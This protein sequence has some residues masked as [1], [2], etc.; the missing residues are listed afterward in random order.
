M[1]VFEVA[2]GTSIMSFFLRAIGTTFGSLWGWAAYEARG[3]DPVVCTAMFFIGLI[4]AVY[5][6]LGSQHTKAGVVAMNSMSVVAIST[7]LQ[8]VPGEMS[9][10]LQTYVWLT[11][12]KVLGQKPS[13]SGGLPS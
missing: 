2:I 10:L 12:P 9:R 8:T 1:L 11:V 3:G 13:S 6:Q 4:P 7:E 5:V